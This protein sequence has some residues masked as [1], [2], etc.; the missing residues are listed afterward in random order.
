MLKVVIEALDYEWDFEIKKDGNVYRLIAI[1]SKNGNPK[2]ESKAWGAETKD[3][4][5]IKEIERLIFA[6]HKNPHKP[7]CITILDAVITRIIYDFKGPKI[8]LE[9][10]NFDEDTNEHSLMEHIFRL[11]SEQIKDPML[12]KLH[13]PWIKEN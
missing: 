11:F 2:D 4:T 3:D 6:A 1:C 5:L 12:E 8:N 10:W 9:I 13:R 7:T